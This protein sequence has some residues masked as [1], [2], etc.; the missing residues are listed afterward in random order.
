MKIFAVDWSKLKIFADDNLNVNQNLKFA[1]GRIE[2]IVNNNNAFQ[3]LLLKG[4]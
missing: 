1:N 4:H 2:N 3:S